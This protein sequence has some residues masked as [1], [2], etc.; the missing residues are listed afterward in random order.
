M[1][2]DTVRVYDEATSCYKM[3][4]TLEPGVKNSEANKDT[5]LVLYGDGSARLQGTPS[6][7]LRPRESFR[8]V[9]VAE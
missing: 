9:L 7:A 6:K 8:K 4:V 1:P 2:D 3:T 5:C